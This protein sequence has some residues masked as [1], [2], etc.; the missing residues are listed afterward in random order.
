MNEEM[1]AELRKISRLLSIIAIKGHSQAEAIAIL[2]NAG[3]A[4]KEIAEYLGITANAVALTLKR[5]RNK[6]K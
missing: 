3:L 6:K 5:Q 1:L 4:Q 2:S